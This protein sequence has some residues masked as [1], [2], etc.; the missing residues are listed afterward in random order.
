[1]VP[2]T[3]HCMAHWRCCT[4]MYN[5]RNNQREYLHKQCLNASFCVHDDS[6][7]GRNKGE[8]LKMVSLYG[9]A[10][11]ALMPQ[12]PCGGVLR[13]RVPVCVPVV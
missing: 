2:L 12:V 10:W 7:G 4:G 9:Q 3:L 6:A 1:M 13:R 5:V 11:A 8:K